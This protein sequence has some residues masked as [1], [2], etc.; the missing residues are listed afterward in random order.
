MI[1][2]LVLAG[3]Q[4]RRMGGVDKGLQVFRGQPLAAHAIACL[5]PQ[6]AHLIVSA[7]RNLNAYAAFGHPVVG[8]SVAGF[9]GP[10]A[11]LHAGLAACGDDKLVTVPCDS[12]HF[13]LD[14]V[15][16]L[17]A[18][19]EATAADIALP[20]AGGRLQPAFLLCR[21]ALLADLAAYLAGGGR[22]MQEWIGRHAHVAVDFADAAD[23]ANINT[24]AE[25]QQLEASS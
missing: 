21:R 15:A 25:L 3:G 22:R 14:F 12:P 11:G 1:T 20:R 18:A 13:P 24:L 16:R 5:A 19:L 7:N 9:A 10:L 17:D 6:V 23:F 8:D 2:G 4:G